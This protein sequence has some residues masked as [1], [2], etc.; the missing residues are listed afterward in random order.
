MKNHN[1]I[2][3]GFLLLLPLRITAQEFTAKRYIDTIRYEIKYGR[4]II[5]VTVNQMQCKY[6][7]DTGGQTAT[8]W[9]DA[10]TMGGKLAGA[11]KVTADM[12][13][14]ANMYSMGKL[15]KVKIGNHLILPE[16]TT[17]ALPNIKG[18]RDLGVVGILGGDAF[19]DV[20]MS[21]VSS[22]R[23]IHIHYPYRPK[24]LKLNDG[25]PLADS[26]TWQVNFPLSFSG[27]SVQV[28][29][30][31]GV[32]ELLTMNE[33]DYLL[34]AQIYA[35]TVVH[36]GKGT[37]GAGLEGLAEPKHLKQVRLDKFTLG[38]KSF[39]NP[40][41]LVA[42]DVPTILGAEVLRYGIVTID[43]PRGRFY[44][45]P[46][47][48]S[49]VDLSKAAPIW[50]VSILPARGKFEI[51]TVWEPLI[52]RVDIGDEVIAVNGKD[53]T[54]LPLSEI[55]VSDIFDQITS[56][57]ATITIRRRKRKFDIN[58]YRR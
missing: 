47:K 19:K 46:Y 52:D 9:E 37:L 18:F 27:T 25:I 14:K 55:A 57:E 58:I 6:I 21:L 2:L 10:K 36:K 20:V 13:G 45:Q 11:N 26:E 49:P 56:S 48:Q 29:F 42:S 16:L 4:I 39:K 3:S 22:S 50:S 30:D 44:F 41:C 12:N 7:L 40:T 53:I 43:Y 23:E 15:P 33:K 28:M 54:R 38:G 8:I 24:G 5:P 17:I 35:A 32:P 34:L 1:Y 51:A 31:T